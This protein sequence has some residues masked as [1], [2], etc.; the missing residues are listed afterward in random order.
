MVCNYSIRGVLGCCVRCKSWKVI[1][2]L[3]ILFIF[4]AG[5][6]KAVA[7]TLADH[8]DISIFRFKDRKFWDKNV[9]WKYAKVIFAYKV[10]GWHLANSGM[11]V[12]ICLAIALHHPYTYWW[13]E[14]VAAGLIFNLSF[15]IFYN[16]VLR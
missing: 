11:I 1:P 6:F 16:K 3:T 4:L 13:L 5:M 8:F 7:D 10:D 2:W 9:S 12:S 15:N 14:V